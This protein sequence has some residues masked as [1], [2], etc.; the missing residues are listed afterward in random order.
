MRPELT[1]Y[2]YD[3]MMG[4]TLAAAA[5][6]P[7]GTQKETDLA[8]TYLPYYRGIADAFF[9][10]GD[11]GIQLLKLLA[12]YYENILTAREKGKKISVNTQ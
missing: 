8:L 3:W 2:N 5:R 11:P 7:R 12:K 10:A 9:S 1:E 4:K 6:V